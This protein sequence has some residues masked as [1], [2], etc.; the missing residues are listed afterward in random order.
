MSASITGGVTGIVV[1]TDP[2][3]LKLTG[4]TMSVSA[5][6]IFY[7]SSLP[8]YTEYGAWGMGLTKTATNQVNYFDADGLKVKTNNV[9]FEISSTAIKFPDNTTLYSAPPNDARNL[10][11]RV[12]NGNDISTSGVSGSG[13]TGNNG[14]GFSV[15]CSTLT[16]AGIAHRYLNS[17]ANAP[18]SVGQQKGRINWSKGVRTKCRVVLDTALDATATV[19]FSIGKIASE[20]STTAPADILGTTKGVGFKIIGSGPVQLVVSNGTGTTTVSTNST[21][22]PTAAVAFDAEIISDGAG[23]VSLYINGSTTASATTTGGPTGISNTTT[24]TSIGA[25]YQVTSASAPVN[26]VFF[27]HIHTQIDI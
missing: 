23:N 14:A 22:T 15:G 27:G 19:R 9:G 11:Y 16:G 2:T 8:T 5:T 18:Q 24:A 20:Y 21:F 17:T 13:T 25:E 12:Y 10:S 4:G 7:P 1:E 3:A 6:S 26:V